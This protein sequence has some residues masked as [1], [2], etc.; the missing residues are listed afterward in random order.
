ML[1][2]QRASLPLWNVSGG[3][4]YLGTEIPAT[5]SPSSGGSQVATQS[6]LGLLNGA[7]YVVG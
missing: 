6:G 5:L 4:D 2:S 3:P 7:S 1:V